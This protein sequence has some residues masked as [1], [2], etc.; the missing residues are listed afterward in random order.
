MF[1]TC[2]ET[3][4]QLLY[5]PVAAETDETFDASLFSFFIIVAPIMIAR[6]QV[7]C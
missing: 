2:C 7:R 1:V 5:G 6:L 4:S 3:S